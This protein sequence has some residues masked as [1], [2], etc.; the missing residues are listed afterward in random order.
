[1]SAKGSRPKMLATSRRT[2]GMRVAP[3]TRITPESCFASRPASRSARRAGCSQRSRTGLTT[4]SSSARV[5]SPRQ[6]SPDVRS[7][8]TSVVLSLVSASFASRAAS[9]TRRVRV[10]SPAASSGKPICRNRCAASV[11]SKSS[12]PR[13]ESPPVDF[14]SNTPP[15]NFRIDMSNVPPPRSN[16]AKIPSACLSRP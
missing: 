11:R 8:A 14:T 15:S 12:P 1:M 2:I 6:I 7:I 10:R 5:S 16:T 3:P 9:S 4:S 13:A